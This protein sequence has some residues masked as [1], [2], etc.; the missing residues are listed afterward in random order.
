M[1]IIGHRGAKGLAKENSI[2]SIQLALNAGVDMV[3]LDLRM[4]GSSIVL[5]HDPTIPSHSCTD[6]GEA[7]RVING[8]VAIN[9][10]IKES[11]DLHK[12]QTLLKEY[13]GEIVFSSFKFS[14]L[15]ELQQ[16][17]PEYSV[18][19]LEKWS[20][21]RAVAE[22]E[23]LHTKRIHIN[24]SWLWGSFVRSLKHRGYSVYAYTVNNTDRGEELASWGVDGIFTD[25]PDRFL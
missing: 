16:A 13:N 12:L 23:L 25:Y 15:Q 2:E 4:Q 18:A 9:L 6:L 19:V 20:G 21:L 11:I 22:A 7:I 17:L 8:N 10:E 24:Q 5:S 3:E 14:L 1:Q